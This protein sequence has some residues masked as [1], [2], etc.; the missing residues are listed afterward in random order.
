MA[1]RSSKK[2]VKAAKKHPKLVAFIIIL[3]A[4]VIALGVLLYFLKPELF[5]FGKGGAE[6]PREGMKEEI[7]GA[8][9]S[10][11]FPMLGNKSAG[12]CILIDCGDT[13][14]LIDAGSEQNSATTIKSYVDDYCSD[15][16]LEYVIATHADS[17]HISAFYGNSAGNTR[18][19][20]LYQY[21]IGTLIKFDRSDKDLKTDKGNNTL[22]ANFLD[23]VDMLKGK[24]TAVYTGSDCYDEKDG[25][26]RTYFLDEDRTLSITILYNYYYYNKAADENNYSVV[27]LLTKEE[28]EK[29]THYLFTGDLEEDGERR[30]VAHYP[31]ESRDEKYDILP[32]VEL[33]KAGHHGSKTS[34]TKELI[35]TIKPKNVVVCCCVGA[36]EYTVAND[37]TFPT[38]QMLETVMKYTVNIYAPLQAT[39]LPELSADGNFAA[40]KWS[41]SERNGNIVFY[42]KEG[43]LKLYCSNGNVTLP[44]TDW[45]KKYRV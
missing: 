21:E 45:F 3:V 15:G 33:Y 24:G 30:M 10:I 43:G 22:Y 5:K 1:K 37:N 6:P 14:V 11:H 9:F 25:A 28:G 26:K 2:A 32:E 13:E 35:D 23:A 7:E 41:Y 16:K 4:V 20:I 17:D 31:S 36:P 8:N 38:R 19:G 42:M 27:T 34:S 44:D 12:D 18:T 29:S 39:E 40:K